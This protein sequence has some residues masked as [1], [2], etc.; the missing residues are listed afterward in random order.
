MKKV[1]VLTIV[2]SLTG[3]SLAGDWSV[4][5]QKVT[6]AGQELLA[7]SL[8]K[9]PEGLES[10]YGFADRSEFARATVGIPYQMF[11]VNPGRGTVEPMGSWRLPVLVDGA[12]RALLTVYKKDGAYRFAEFGAAQLAND[13]G[14]LERSQVKNRTGIRRAIFRVFELKCD[15][16][17]IA[18]EDSPIESGDI[19]PLQSARTFLGLS[20]NDKFSFAQ[21]KEL[22]H[23]NLR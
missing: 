1:T 19:H 4:L 16:L 15:F 18:W 20:R 5:E 8:A 7:S 23:K 11:A 9:V 6:A 17:V 3:L 10:N 21:F 12:Y 14:S 2:L 22:L 13:L